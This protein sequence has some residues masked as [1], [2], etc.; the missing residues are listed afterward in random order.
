M[1][2]L[3][4]LLQTTVDLSNT[5]IAA[6]GIVTV[7]SVI[8]TSIRSGNSSKHQQSTQLSIS[9]MQK[10][11]NDIKEF[12]KPLVVNETFNQ[13]IDKYVKG[14]YMYAQ[15]DELAL[16]FLELLGT[17]I[18]GF[19][20]SIIR[21]KFDELTNEDITAKYEY[22]STYVRNAYINFNED[23]VNKD[24]RPKM[25]DLCADYLYEITIIRDDTFNHKLERFKTVT[26]KFTQDTLK[27]F[28]SKYNNFKSRN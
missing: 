1:I 24:F 21:V 2:T 15:D 13:S 23:F 25:K 11:I 5:I 6:T 28:V 22:W 17:V 26:D 18:K 9:N 8:Y 20:N 10:D 12:I 14:S 7:G 16:H 27:L 3:T 4:I 19:A